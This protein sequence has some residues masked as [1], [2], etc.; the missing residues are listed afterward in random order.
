MPDHAPWRQSPDDPRTAAGWLWTE[1][2]RPLQGAVESLGCLGQIGVVALFVFGHAM[3]AIALLLATFL[4]KPLSR[5]GPGRA[6]VEPLLTLP[7]P[8]AA[9]PCGVEVSRGGRVVGVDR[10]AVTFL[11]GW[12]QYEG[13]RTSFSLSRADVVR[14]DQNGITLTEGGVSFV[15][16]PH[17]EKAFS[18]ALDRWYRLDPAAKGISILP[19]VQVHPTAFARARMD[20][21]TAAFKVVQAAAVALAITA[22]FH[23]SFFL[24]VLLGGPLEFLGALSSL[25][26]LRRMAKRDRRALGGENECAFGRKDR[27]VA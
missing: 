18:T 14:R 21:L 3:A 20:A 10:G 17:V 25:A 1:R 15:P 13:F 9:F 6:S 26:R 5:L 12:L 4:L 19:P 8:A 24:L 2:Y 23:S 16:D 27:E 7:P 11:E 22:Y